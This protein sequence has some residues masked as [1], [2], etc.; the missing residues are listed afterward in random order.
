MSNQVH[1]M[2]MHPYTQ[3]NNPVK[4]HLPAPYGFQDLAPR[5]FKSQGPFGKFKG[6]IK[7]T[8]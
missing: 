5:R 7:F 4:Y 6:Q 8:P 1:I 2:T 3:T